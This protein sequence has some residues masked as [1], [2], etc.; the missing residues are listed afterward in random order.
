VDRECRKAGK[1]RSEVICLSVERP[2]FFINGSN[3][4]NSTPGGM[5]EGE[6]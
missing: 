2:G 3:I 4:V 6:P 1:Y 5:Y